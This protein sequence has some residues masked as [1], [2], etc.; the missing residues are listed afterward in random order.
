MARPQPRIGLALS[1]GGYR[2]AAF[3]IGT[4]RKLHELGILQRVDVISTISGGSIAGAYYLTHNA[5]FDKFEEGLRNALQKSTV[6]R[7]LTSTRFLAVLVAYSVFVALLGS[8]SYWG[9]FD[10]GW[11]LLALLVGAALIVIFLHNLLDLTDITRQVYHDLFFHDKRLRDLPPHPVAAIN[12]TNLDTGTLWTFSR[13]QM[14]DST[15]RFMRD[16]LGPI[17]F[18]VDDFPVALAVACSTAV[19]FPFNPV[20]IESRYFQHPSDTDRI[21]PRLMDGGIYD[22]QGIHRLTQSFDPTFRC[23]IVICSDGSAPLRKRFRAMNPL[24]VLNRV[25]EL[26]MR[27]VKTLQFVRDV[28]QDQRETVKEIAYFSLDWEYERCLE[29]FY[30]AFKANRIS[31]DILKRLGF[32]KAFASRLSKITQEEFVDFLKNRIGYD[33]IIAQ[34]LSKEDIA[35]ISSIGTNLTALSSD[36]IDKLAQHAA[37][38]TEIQVRLYCPS[39]I[40]Q[41]A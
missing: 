16:G 21:S 22:N 17:G 37:S 3:H 6:A 33:R 26:M 20:R 13:E 27:R 23:N 35:S 32:T 39:L 29:G 14:G 8:L 12:A 1:G 24:P 15:Y 7:I 40:I 18:T 11:M 4:L 31:R 36:D 25:V 2:A 5:V 10:P 28:Y 19:P 41:T 30:S 34:G 9:V 38:L